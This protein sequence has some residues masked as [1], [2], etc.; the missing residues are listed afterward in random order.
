M[1]NPSDEN[2]FEV[3]RTQKAGGQET[4]C[5]QERGALGCWNSIH[6]DQEKG[7][8]TRENG[9]CYVVVN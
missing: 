1:K 5:N 3:G 7:L 4:R 9:C 2:I 8:W 6:I